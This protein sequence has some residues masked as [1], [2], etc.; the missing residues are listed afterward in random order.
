MTL[1]PPRNSNS[2]LTG[3]PGSAVTA[4][5]WA[6]AWHAPSYWRESMLWAC[7]RCMPAFFERRTA[8]CSTWLMPLNVGGNHWVL[9]VLFWHQQLLVFCNSLGD[10]PDPRD[11]R[12]AQVLM[13]SAVPSL[14]WTGWRLVVPSTPPA[15]GRLELRLPG[16]LARPGSCHRHNRTLLPRGGGEHHCSDP[17]LIPYYLHFFLYPNLISFY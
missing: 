11:T 7:R 3:T 4:V 1:L 8:P 6:V 2:V 10:L 12:A 15:N 17:G 16:V 9:F 5:L 14:K 13:A